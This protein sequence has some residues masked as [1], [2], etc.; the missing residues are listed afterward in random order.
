MKEK[1]HRWVTIERPKEGSR[2]LA[3]ILEQMRF[4]NIP[5]QTELGSNGMVRV[6]VRE[7]DQTIAN[8]TINMTVTVE[9]ESMDLHDN[10][11]FF[12]LD[13]IE[14]EAEEDDWDDEDNGPTLEALPTFNCA[15]PDGVVVMVEVQSSHMSG[16]IWAE[17]P[18]YVLFKGRPIVYKYIGV[19]EDHWNELLATAVARHNGIQEA[20]VGE[21]FNELVKVPAEK[22]EISVYRSDNGGWVTVPPKADRK[23]ERIA[24]R[25]E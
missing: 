2:K 12:A 7:Q 10:H 21:V 15:T 3:W 22:G 13:P 19:S 20:S 4:A 18:L 23:K 16:M 8:R 11:E 1:L 5:T 14:E 6:K 9:M 17:G 24:K 25:G